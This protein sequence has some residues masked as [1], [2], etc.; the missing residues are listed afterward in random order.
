MRIVLVFDV[1]CGIVHGISERNMN[2]DELLPLCLETAKAEIQ[3]FN[4]AH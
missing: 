4:V 3:I 2:L 1:F